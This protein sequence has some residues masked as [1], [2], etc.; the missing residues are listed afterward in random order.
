[1]KGTVRIIA[2]TL[3]GK[4]IPFL[5]SRYGDA[6]ITPQ[7][8]KG[9]LFS[10]LGE[11]LDGKVFIDLF[12]GSGQ[13]GIEALSRGADSVIFNEAERSRYIF[14]RDFISA[15]NTGQKAITLNMKADNALKYIAGRGIRADIIFIDPPYEKVKG[16]AGSYCGIIEMLAEADVLK[17]DGVIVVQHFSSNILPDKC[18]LYTRTSMKKYGTTSLS[19]Y[20]IDLDASNQPV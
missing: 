15:I 12:S 3:R 8:V 19:V 14:I 11:H 4:V 6:D 17:P 5:N 13:M 18:S 20:A 16:E 10:M 1:V 9:A 7:K 2:G